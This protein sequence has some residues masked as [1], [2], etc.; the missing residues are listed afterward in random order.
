MSSAESYALGIVHWRVEQQIAAVLARAF[1]DDPLV[2]AMCGAPPAQRERRMVWSFRIAVRGH[3]LAAQ[4]GWALTGPDAAPVGAVLT[5]R[6]C[7]QM[8][9]GADVLFTL[10]A[11][12]H[13]GVRTGVRGAQAARIIAAHAPPQPFTYLR[14]L[15]VHPD[16]HGCG[17]GSRLVEQVVRSASPS[18]PVYLE[19]AKEKNVAFYTRHGFECIGEF[20]CL[21]VPVWRMLRPAAESASATAT[22]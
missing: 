12:L 17:L 11:L 18:L 10:R 16:L 9:V 15:G 7:V 4:P 8:D 14:T 21:G 2:V 22:T 19:T 3:C 1:V 6:P 13:M 20:R 5:T